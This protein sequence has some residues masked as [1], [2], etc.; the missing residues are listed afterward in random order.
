M[1]NDGK[2]P[3]LLYIYSRKQCD[4]IAKKITLTLFEEDSKIQSII[5][6]EIDNNLRKLPNFE[7]LS[8]SGYTDLIKNAEKGIAVHHGGITKEFREVI[9]I[10]FKKKY[11]KLV[12]A[13]ETLGIGVNMPV[14]ATIY[15]SLSKFD[16]TKF[17]YLLSLM[18]ILNNQVGQLGDRYKRICYS[19][20]KFIRC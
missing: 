3:A 8:C 10:L 17:R 2:L 7:E 16:G 9:E 1:K 6:K 20:I 18:N 11:F 4:L 15:T 14:K 19:F 5:R 13:T 12:I